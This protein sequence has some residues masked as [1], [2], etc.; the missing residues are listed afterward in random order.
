MAVPMAHFTYDLRATRDQR[1]LC[2]FDIF[3]FER[4]RGMTI[5]RLS[6]SVAS[7]D[8]ECCPGATARIA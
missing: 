4:N 3:D 7:E 2:G 6:S 1:G 5:E 8:F